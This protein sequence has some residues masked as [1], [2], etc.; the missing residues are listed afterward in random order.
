M[1]ERG[2]FNYRWPVNEYYLDLHGK[3]SSF[4]HKKRKVDIQRAATTATVDSE[5]LTSNTDEDTDEE[6]MG[7]QR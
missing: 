1:I 6:D 5:H 7:A 2:C 3:H 4:R